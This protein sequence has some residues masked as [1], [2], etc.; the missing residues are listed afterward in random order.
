M[1]RLVV[2]PCEAHCLHIKWMYK[3]KR[4][5]NGKLDRYKAPLVAC[6][7]DQVFVRDYNVTVA[8][9]IEMSSV[10]LILALARIWRVPAKHGGIPNAYVKAEKEPDLNIF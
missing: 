5:A 1:W 6:G 8:A 10:K 7:N 3:T 4:D 9:L 2:A